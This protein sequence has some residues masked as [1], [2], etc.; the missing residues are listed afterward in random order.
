MKIVRR[1]VGTVEV[2]A[3]Q[4]ALVDEGAVEFN[5]LLTTFLNSPNPRVVVA[6]NDVGY[7]DSTALEKLV[8]AT[9]TLTERGQQL[10]L[11]TV[12][13]TCR[14]I[15]SL[16]GLN[17]RFQYFESVDAAVRSFL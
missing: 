3:P 17:E 16:T 2:L 1:T 5:E 14:E 9:E 7:M 10:K 4:D 13:P 8:S 11:A 6:M 15:L 12:T